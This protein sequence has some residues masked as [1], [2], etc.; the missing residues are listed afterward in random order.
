MHNFRK[1]YFKLSERLEVDLHDVAGQSWT[2][3]WRWPWNIHQSRS[4][5]WLIE[6]MA[7]SRTVMMTLWSTY[8]QF[9]DCAKPISKIPRF[10]MIQ[11]IQNW[12]NPTGFS[13]QTHSPSSGCSTGVTPAYWLGPPGPHVALPTM[14]PT[15]LGS[16]HSATHGTWFCPF[17][18]PRH[19]TLSI[20][21]PM[22]L[23]FVHSATYGTWLCQFCHPRHLPLPTLPPMALSAA[24][25]AF[26]GMWLC[27]FC[28]IISE[29]IP[30]IH[31]FVRKHLITWP[32][33]QPITAGTWLEYPPPSPAI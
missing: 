27:P 32:L 14:L 28:L 15:A 31:T 5:S 21:P 25:Y 11:C 3:S 2:G 26:H 20:L 30:S 1:R 29:S 8:V 16:T 24:Q 23:G 9:N 17:R 12:N 19:L 7:Y 6:H 10:L 4:G 33:W 13:G 18:L 22:A